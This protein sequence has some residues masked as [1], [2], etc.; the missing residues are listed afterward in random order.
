MKILI[1]TKKFPFPLKEGEPIAVTYLSRAL[2]ENGCEVSLLAM[3]TSKH[4]FVMEELPPDYNHFR[5]ICTVEVD[6][7]LKIGEAII[8]MIRG[9]SY[10]LSRFQ[11][12]EFA[13]KLAGLLQNE[14]YDIVQLETTY[15]G[16]YISLIRKYSTARIAVRTHNV[17]HKIWQRIQNN[18]GFGFRKWYLKTQIDKLRDFEMETVKAAD[19]LVAIT[20]E[21]L[22]TF[23]QLGFDGKSTVAPVGLDLSDY[24]P[25]WSTLGF[26]LS[27]GF[28]G[29][30]D[31]LPNQEGILWFIEEVWP[32]IKEAF[33][34]SELHIAG[35]NAPLWLS[36]KISA[37]AI[38]HGEVGNAKVFMNQHSLMIAPLFSGSGIKVKVL[39]AMALGRVVFA[40]PL[41]LEGIKAKN[42]QELFVF[43]DRVEFIDQLRSLTSDDKM[44][45]TGKKARDFIRQHF[46]KKAIA[47]SLITCY[48]KLIT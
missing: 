47:Q 7:R 38:F 21:D 22:E 40:T 20:S 17:E 43:N 9:E 8:A 29:A 35:K 15:L 46:D 28:I 12:Q 10:M 44:T 41:A 33:P 14:S 18:S 39:E 25:D 32:G 4:Y 31:W 42:G 24:N 45:Q 11:S 19:A 5:S 23:T 1:L 27:I 6:N 13:N 2:T 48:Q 30:L 3:N 16:H 26:P 34:Q 36:R 37:L